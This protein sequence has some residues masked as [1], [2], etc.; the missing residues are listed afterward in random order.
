MNIFEKYKQTIF[1][2]TEKHFL[3][4]K[5]DEIDFKKWE[6]ILKLLLFLEEKKS[7]FIPHLEDF[8]S[9]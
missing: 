3:E 6:K 9:D 4:N 1:S 8:T 2:V 5:I 7:I